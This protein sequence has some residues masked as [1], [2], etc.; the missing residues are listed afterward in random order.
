M[1]WTKT[2][3][4]D[5]NVFFLTALKLLILEWSNLTLRHVTNILQY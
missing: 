3:N 4:T 1:Q 5:V 2:I